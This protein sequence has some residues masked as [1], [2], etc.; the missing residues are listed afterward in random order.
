[1]RKLI[2]WILFVIS[3]LQ[4]VAF[5]ET[6]TLQLDAQQITSI[7][8]RTAVRTEQEVYLV[9]PANDGE[10]LVRIPLDGGDASLVAS[11]DDFEDLVAFNNG[12]A[13]LKTENGV[14]TIENCLGSSVSTLYTFGSNAGEKLSVHGSKL[15]VLMGGLLHSIDPDTALCLKLSGAQMLDYVI[16]NGPCGAGRRHWRIHRPAG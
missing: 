12:A 15:L 14:T 11:A 4:C 9:L 16:G 2:A 1:M 6:A 13:Y 7:N 10:I 5:A 3:L 8:H